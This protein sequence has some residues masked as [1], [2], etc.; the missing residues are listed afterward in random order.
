MRV[1]ALLKA[2]IEGGELAPGTRLNI[3]LI[4]DQNGVGRDSVKRALGM[5]E[6]D[7]LTERWPGLGWYVKE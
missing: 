6:A 4:A 3:G 7:G 2:A 1:Y 5:L